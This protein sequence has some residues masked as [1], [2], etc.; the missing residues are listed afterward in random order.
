M[1]AS[2]EEILHPNQNDILQ[3][4]M[5]TGGHLDDAIKAAQFD[6][7]KC[8][9][10]MKTVGSALSQ[11]LTDEPKAEHF[12]ALLQEGQRVSRSL[13]LKWGVNPEDKKNMWMSN[14]IEKAVM[15]Y[16]SPSSPLDDQTIEV[17]ASHLLER[18]Q[19]YPQNNAW[20][21]DASITL[22]LFKGINALS[23]EQMHY[24]FLRKNKENDL[25]VLR[26][27][28]TEVATSFLEEMVSPITPHEDRVVFMAM[29]LDQLFE[30]MALSWKRNA[31]R[32]KQAMAPLT[33][34]QIKA[35]KQANPQGF[36]LKPV[37]EYFEQNAGRLLRLSMQGRKKNKKT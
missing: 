17:L 13:L 36:E 12:S 25:E 14:V 8:M 1:T 26:D 28:V 7:R 3:A 29:I 9:N 24:D 4:E 31:H 35:W 6:V 19:D 32:A 2:F 34:P 10:A 22:S 5:A 21:N 37:V 11:V 23:Q 16:L 30:L 27:K 15:P 20:K 18:A 33:P